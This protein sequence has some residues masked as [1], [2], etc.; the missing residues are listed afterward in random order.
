MVKKTNDVTPDNET[1]NKKSKLLDNQE[2]NTETLKV[3]KD[4]HKDNQEE[5]TETLKVKK[6]KHIDKDNQEEN[7]ETLKVKKEKHKDNKEENTETLKVKKEKSPK[8]KKE[9]IKKEEEQEVKDT[10]KPKIKPIV[11]S[12]PINKFENYIRKFLYIH[13]EKKK[14]NNEEET[15]Q[16]NPEEKTQEEVVIEETNQEDT[17]KVNKKKSQKLSKKI[18]KSDIALAVVNEYVLNKI[19]DN[20]VFFLNKKENIGLSEIN[21]QILYISLEF[22][23]NLTKFFTPNVLLDYNDMFN[24]VDLYCV[25]TDTINIYFF[26]LKFL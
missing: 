13:D 25:P 8:E 20:T 9:E 10:I 23:K 4:K 5:N 6:D 11:V 2:E 21:K 22:D 1:K 24:Y 7:T 19:I 18:S 14:V 3:K 17:K 12:F 16:E 26:S 15:Q